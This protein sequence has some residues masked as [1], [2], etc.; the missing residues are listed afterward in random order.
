MQFRWL[1]AA[2]FL[3][4]L[5]AA[6]HFWALADFL[7]WKYRWFDTPMHLLGGIAIGTSTVALLP[8]YRPLSYLAIIAV[9]AVSWELFEYFAGIAVFPGVNYQW[10]TAHDLLNDAIG[11]TLVYGVARYT[12]WRTPV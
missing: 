6:L 10:D 1:L 9:A 3:T 7:Y 5:L 12:L 8:S 11:A 4:G 2:L